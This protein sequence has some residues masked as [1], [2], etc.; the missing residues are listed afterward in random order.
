M[1]RDFIIGRITVEGA[2]RTEHRSGSRITVGR[3]EEAGYLAARARYR[4]SPRML[5]EAE[6]DSIT[7]LQSVI[8]HLLRVVYYY[9]WIS[10]RYASAIPSKAPLLLRGLP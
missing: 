4:K 10:Y 1:R 9:G 6:P 8:R 2:T 5:R 3:L 7:F